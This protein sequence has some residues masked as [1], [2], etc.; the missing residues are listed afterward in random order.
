LKVR[1]IEIK[2]KK[3][4]PKTIHI[5]Y[6]SNDGSGGEGRRGVGGRGE[7]LSEW[8]IAIGK[9]KKRHMRRRGLVGKT[10]SNFLHYAHR[11]RSI[12]GTAGH[13]ILTPVV[14]YGEKIWS[15]RRFFSFRPGQ[16]ARRPYTLF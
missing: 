5:K 9:L 13:I 7:G 3:E 4:T 1:N 16:K 15:L 6:M 2:L 12:L 14:G 11:H 8:K 10:K